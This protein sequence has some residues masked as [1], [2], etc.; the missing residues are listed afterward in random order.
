MLSR[1]WSIYNGAGGLAPADHFASK[2]YPPQPG[3]N[4]AD[5]LLDIASEPTDAILPDNQTLPVR[6]ERSGTSRLSGTGSDDGAPSKEKA[7]VPPEDRVAI[8]QDI[9]TEKRS[10]LPGRVLHRSNY[11]ST[12]LTQFQVLCGREWKILR[13]SVSMQ[14]VVPQN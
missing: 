12:F 5:H 1:G 11:A 6:W 13:R 4:V 9:P 2:G 8:E 3:Y 7:N 14:Y 10:T